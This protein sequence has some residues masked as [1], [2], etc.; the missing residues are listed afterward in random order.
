MVLTLASGMVIG[1]VG[2]L[3][4][5]RFLMS[6][7]LLV[8]GPPPPPP[9][10]PEMVARFRKGL[11]LTPDQ[12]AEFERIVSS[13]VEA[14]HQIIEANA[15]RID[16]EFEAMRN[17]VSSTLDPKNREIW[18]ERT[19]Q[20]LRMIRRSRSQSGKEEDRRESERPEPNKSPDLTSPP[21]TVPQ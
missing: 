12:A 13:H 14:I 1:A 18:L 3:V 8:P 21:P 10:M 17:Q 5:G 6:H 2:A 11:D 4:G 19:E 9:P 7:H 20:T 15:P 16:A